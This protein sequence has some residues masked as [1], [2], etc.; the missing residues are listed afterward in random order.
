[1]LVILGFL[2]GL[3]NIKDKETTHFLIAALALGMGSTALSP[4]AGI[5]GMDMVFDIFRNIALFVSPAAFVVAIKA[6]YEIAREEKKKVQNKKAVPQN[7]KA[8][9]NPSLFLSYCTP[10]KRI[11][12]N[13]F[14][15]KKTIKA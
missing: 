3:L 12:L 4:L 13:T 8:D 1:L 7:K 6:I 14:F 5:V 10:K 11:N 2:V 15:N 9:R